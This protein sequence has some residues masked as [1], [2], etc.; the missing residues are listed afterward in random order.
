VPR[1][2]P[3]AI[4]PGSVPFLFTAAFDGSQR[5]SGWL[6]V[7]RFARSVK[8]SSGKPAHFTF[9]INTCYFDTAKVPSTIGRAQRRDEVLVRRALAQ[10]AVNE[11]HEIASHGVG[12]HDGSTWTVAAWRQEFDSFHAVADALV[13]APVRDEAGRA[14]FPRFSPRVGAAPGQAGAACSSDADCEGGPC[15]DLGD[16]GR[17]CAPACNLK[18]RCPEGFVCGAPFFRED[19][20]VCLPPP[21]FPVVHGGETLFDGRGAPRVGRTSLKPLPARG[22]RAPFLGAND[23]MV[24]VLMERGYR[25]DTSLGAPPG[26]PRVLTVRRGGPELLELGLVAWPGVRAIPMDYNYLQLKVDGS[27]MV[28]DYKSAVL[29]AFAA[30]VPFNIGHHFARWEGG[31]YQRALEDT[32]RFTAAGCPGDD[33]R[34]RCPGAVVAS[35]AEVVAALDAAG[36]SSS[37]AE[38]GTE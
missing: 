25:Y 13:F 21:D 37:R 17:L 6:D 2:T 24:Q 20:D 31:A 15:A 10:I 8:A 18:K 22:F 16:A 32:V 23:A 27:R 26:P 4:A 28:E 29:Q 11:G 12:H 7:L 5:F 36:T 19:E 9:F 38:G 3:L 30:G 14:V 33:G 1:Q 34:A 35:F